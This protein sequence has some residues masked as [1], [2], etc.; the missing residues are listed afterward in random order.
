VLRLLTVAD[1]CD[2]K[3]GPVKTVPK[4]FDWLSC[5]VLCRHFRNRT[6]RGV[7]RKCGVWISVSFA[8]NL[9]LFFY[10]L[11]FLIVKKLLGGW[12]RTPVKHASESCSVD[13]VLS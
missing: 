4:F 7:A 1:R 13:R 3:L 10:S 2:D 11:C 6:A 9:V 12:T 5:P 8:L